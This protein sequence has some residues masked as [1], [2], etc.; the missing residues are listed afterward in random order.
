VRD[1]HPNKPITILGKDTSARNE[2]PVQA[3]DRGGASRG[4]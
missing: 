4:R 1:K 3:A 2:S